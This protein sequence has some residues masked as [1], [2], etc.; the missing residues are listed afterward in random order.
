LYEIGYLKEEGPDFSI[1]TE[2]L[3]DEIAKIA[4]PQLGRT[5]YECALC[6]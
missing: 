6:S 3:D 5:N 1:D 2:K 4:G